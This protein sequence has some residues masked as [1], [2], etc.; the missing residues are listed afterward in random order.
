MQWTRHSGAP[1]WHSMRAPNDGAASGGR[2]A[3]AA[4]ASRSNAS[5]PHRAQ[6]FAR[7]AWRHPQ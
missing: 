2:R 5:L 4:R 1:E 6:I 3:A 7:S